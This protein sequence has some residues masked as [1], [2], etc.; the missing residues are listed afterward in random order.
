[1]HS[2]PEASLVP[3]L[4]GVACKYAL[5]SV[6]WL[7]VSRIRHQ[8]DHDGR[9]ALGSI[10]DRRSCRQVERSPRVPGDRGTAVLVAGL[11]LNDFRKVSMPTIEH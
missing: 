10:E 7:L 11:K 8:R 9:A 3:A 1:M 6:Y 4:L 2:S 5:K